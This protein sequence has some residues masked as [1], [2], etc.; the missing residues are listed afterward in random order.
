MEKLGSTGEFETQIQGKHVLEGQ[1]EEAK[2]GLQNG[3]AVLPRSLNSNGT[4]KNI[5]GESL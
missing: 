1:E 5:T 3:V 2:R 4:G